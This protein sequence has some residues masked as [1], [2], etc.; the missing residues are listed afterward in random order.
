MK[1]LLSLFIAMLMLFAVTP[2]G[3]TATEEEPIDAEAAVKTAQT[4]ILPADELQVIR[5][6]YIE[7]VDN[8]VFGEHPDYTYENYEWNDFYIYDLKWYCFNEEEDIVF[9]MTSEDVF[10]DEECGYYAQLSIAPKDG[11]RFADME[12]LEVYSNM[13]NIEYALDE[14]GMLQ[15][16]STDYTAHGEAYDP[17]VIDSAEILYFEAPEYG[18]L[19][20]R[21]F[22]CPEE[23]EEYEYGLIDANWHWVF[24]DT[25]R[26]MYKYDYFINEGTYYCEIILASRFGFEFGPETTALIDGSDENV[27]SVTVDEF[28]RLVIRTI[29]FTCPDPVLVNEFDITVEINPGEGYDS[30]AVDPDWCMAEWI[31]DGDGEYCVC[32]YDENGD[33]TEY[34]GD[35]SEEGNV[36]FIRFYASIKPGYALS[37]EFIP[38]VNGDEDFVSSFVVSQSS[39]PRYLRLYTEDFT[40]DEPAMIP[41][42]VSGNGIVDT[43]DALLVLRMALGITSCE[44]DDVSVCDMDGNGVIDTM[45]ALYILRIALGITQ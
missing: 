13:P 25:D 14:E 6:V 15:V 24:E 10:D 12:A 38:T 32:T 4:E 44:D 34:Y 17:E 1:K 29:D 40:M 20:K 11:F 7:G 28:G 19:P 5:E 18:A 31:R 36:Y 39:Y 16:F 35:F 45:D 33:P 30:V 9:E 27:Q 22:V 3:M 23:E 41:G 2:T 21:W 43:E 8:P 26:L 37:E 42:D